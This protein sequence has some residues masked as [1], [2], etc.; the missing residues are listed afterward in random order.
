MYMDF[1]NKQEYKIYVG[2]LI[3]VNR[4][5]SREDPLDPLLFQVQHGIG[6]TRKNRVILFIEK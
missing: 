4:S 3:G 2:V 6:W 1:N 5:K